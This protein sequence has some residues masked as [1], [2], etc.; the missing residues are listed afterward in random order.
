M[1]DK[2]WIAY[3]KI[4]G[5]ATGAS[6]TPNYTLSKLPKF[7]YGI[8]ERQVENVNTSELLQSN[9]PLPDMSIP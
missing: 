6:D 4:R 8:V 1:A 9:E 7:N 2:K 5:T 3:H